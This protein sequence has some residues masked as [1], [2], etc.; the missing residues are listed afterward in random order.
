MCGPL[1]VELVPKSSS[2]NPP[3]SGLQ[4]CWLQRHSAY[5]TGK[6]NKALIKLP[7]DVLP[8]SSVRAT[9]HRGLRAH[10]HCTSNTLIGGKGAAGETRFK[11]RLRDQRSMW[12]QDGCKVYMGLYM[13]S[14]GS[15][16][17]GHL[18][19]FWKSPLGGRPNRKPG[20]HG[21]PK[22]H[23]RGFILFYFVWGPCVNWGYG[24]IWFH[25]TFE[26]SWPCYIILEVSW[27][28]LW[29]LSF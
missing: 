11:L 15:C 18:N 12:M 23:N 22:S 29:T 9:S 24:H 28:N 5:V 10:G 25:T 3:S 2:P 6:C 26:G 21:T 16:F 17:H 20:D 14:N 27:D 1:Q 8:S 7:N 19:Y 13:A 4:R